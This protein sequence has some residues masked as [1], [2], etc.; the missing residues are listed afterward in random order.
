MSV[1]LGVCVVLL[2]VFG[3]FSALVLLGAIV[4]AVVGD[5][6]ESLEARCER[7]AIDDRRA[8]REDLFL[9]REERYHARVAERIAEEAQD[10]L[11]KVAP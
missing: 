4:G 11:A 9:A 6:R 3:F 1:F 10:H 7:L 8:R 2:G 5:A